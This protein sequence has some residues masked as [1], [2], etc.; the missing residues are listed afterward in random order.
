MFPSIKAA[1]FGKN[2]KK[3]SIVTVFR[4]CVIEN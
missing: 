2:L 1:I 4:D 3:E